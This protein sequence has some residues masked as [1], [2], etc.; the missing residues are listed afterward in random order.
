MQKRFFVSSLAITA[1]IAAMV[2]LVSC[3]SSTKSDRTIAGTVESSEQKEAEVEQI[4]LQGV[5]DQ[6]MRGAKGKHLELGNKP[7]RVKTLDDGYLEELAGPGGQVKV[8]SAFFITDNDLALRKKLAVIQNAKKELRLVYFIWADDYTSSAL[9]NELL[10]AANRGVKIEIIV[11][12]ITNYKKLDLFKSLYEASGKRIKT[13]FYNFPSQQM[14]AD[15]NYMTLPCPKSEAV[16]HEFKKKVMATLPSDKLTPFGKLFLTGIYGRSAAAMK[17]AIGMGAQINPADYKSNAAIGE[18]DPEAMMQLAKLVLGALQGNFLDKIKLSIAMATY[19]EKIEPVLNELKGRFP[20]G[21]ENGTSESAKMWDHFSDYVHHKL[22]LADNTELVM[23]G[24]NIED[25]YHV[26]ERIK[27][28]RNKYL[29]EDTDIWMK[30]N[31][32]ADPK[33]FQ[34]IADRYEDMRKST[35]VASLQTVEEHLE[36]EFV[37]N[38]GKSKT[39]IGSAQRAMGMCLQQAQAGQVAPETLGQCILQTLRKPELGYVNFATR[40]AEVLETIQANHAT[41]K[42]HDAVQ[43]KNELKQLTKRDLERAK[44]YYLENLSVKRG[45]NQERIEGSKFGFEKENNK[46]IHAAWYRGLEGAC[47]ESQR[48]EGGKA[49]YS[50][51][52]PVRVIFNSAYLIMPS[53]LIHKFA[54]MMN[55][56]FGNCSNVKITFITNSPFTSDLAP[57]NILA[58]YQLGVLFDHYRQLESKKDSHD[59]RLLKRDDSGDYSRFVPAQEGEPGAVRFKLDEFWPTLEYFEWAPAN[60]QDMVGLKEKPDSLHSKV[61]L[62][63]NDIIIGSANADF[64]SYLMDT[65]NAMLIRNALDMNKAYAE[66][67]DGLAASGRIVNKMDSMVNRTFADL[68]AEN[69]KALDVFAAKYNQ[70]TR[71]DR[72]GDQIL[73]YLDFAGSKIY[74][75]TGSLLVHRQEFENAKTNSDSGQDPDRW[76]RTQKLNKDA[77]A[78]DNMFK[79]F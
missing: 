38:T 45:N 61:T 56:D 9:M 28:A 11:D 52:N 71:L 48:K 76:P 34:W 39:D 5:P 64:R 72:F 78:M 32:K 31:L 21:L 37:A 67:I 65:N 69:S 20:V 53:G 30:A 55:R 33:G 79:V 23:G 44:F 74:T 50:K 27:G 26:D 60:Y 66:Y 70:Q 15:A 3:V 42:K 41:Y 13:Y 8:S 59:G 16:C 18:E 73:N 19:G 14:V 58:K 35:M 77:N 4:A 51:A 68:R 40:K 17:A 49:V 10:K 63:G 36:Y 1:G 22:V 6:I 7:F 12:L 2:G 29:F 24:R 47:V 25:S 54:Q 75:T 43:S 46:N 57:I 62:I